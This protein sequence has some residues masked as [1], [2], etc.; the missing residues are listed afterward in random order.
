MNSNQNKNSGIQNF[1]IVVIAGG[2]AG[3]AVSVSLLKRNTKLK[4]AIVE[5]NDKHYYQSVS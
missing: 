2:S 4:I 1:D 3:I 5:P